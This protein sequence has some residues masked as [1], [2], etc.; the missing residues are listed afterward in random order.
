MARNRGQQKTESGGRAA[1][2]A[3][4]TPEELLSQGK[5]LNSQKR[6]RKQKEEIELDGDNSQD[7]ITP[8]SK[9]TKTIGSTPGSP[10]EANSDVDRKKLDALQGHG[11]LPLQDSDHVTVDEASPETML[12]LVYL[13][14]LTSA[15]ISHVLAYKSV[16]CL[17]EADYHDLR[18]LRKSTWEE[19]T[20]VLTKGGYTW[21]REKTARALGELTAFVE[22]KH[23]Q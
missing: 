2:K 7:E 16:K 9:K 15:R 11:V 6:Q 19:R 20:K 23:G 13:A 4:N 22:E 17:L 8:A 5:N 1:A 14:I 21:Y 12:A 3:T 18:I 10:E